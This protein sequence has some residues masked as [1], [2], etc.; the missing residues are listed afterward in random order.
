MKTA[1]AWPVSDRKRYG[2]RT[3]IGLLGSILFLIFISTAVYA[4]QT[5]GPPAH[6][7]TY[8]CSKVQWLQ[9]DHKYLGFSHKSKHQYFFRGKWLQPACEAADCFNPNWDPDCDDQ[10]CFT[11]DWD[12]EVSGKYDEQTD[13]FSENV[14]MTGNIPTKGGGFVKI[15][16]EF[17]VSGK[18]SLDPWIFPTLA[19]SDFTSQCTLDRWT[20]SYGTADQP[21]H[22][23]EIPPIFFSRC[24]FTAEERGALGKEKPV[25]LTCTDSQIKA[26]PTVVFPTPNQNFNDYKDAYAEVKMPCLPPMPDSTANGFNYILEEKIV[27][28]G[29]AQYWLPFCNPCRIDMVPS[30]YN[31]VSRGL[32][33]L[34]LERAGD[35]RI[36]FN[37]QVQTQANLLAGD[38]TDWIYFSARP[39]ISSKLDRTKTQKVSAG[40]LQ[41]ATAPA[42]IVNNIRV[43]PQRPKAGQV[44]EIWIDFFNKGKGPTKATQKYYA[45]C[46][47][48]NGGPPVWNPGPHPLEHIIPPNQS[49]QVVFKGS[50]KDSGNYV[51][52]IKPDPMAS[53]VTFAKMITFTVDPP[54]SPQLKVKPKSG[55][56]QK[57]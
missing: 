13:R 57:P 52:A 51:L 3:L 31:Y 25:P 48:Q 17:L 41:S 1:V 46:T 18:M 2:M 16:R 30:Q 24:A 38:Y 27:E 29:G 6:E 7:D 34:N 32:K 14:K 4:K 9:K 47:P 12:I 10:S 40:A 36:K 15:Y 45:T 50:I 55:V 56:M 21:H 8:D 53:D 54:L 37:Q 33:K 5:F 35:Y 26:K 20:N 42:V 39:L 44:F 43:N 49:V 23:Y 22:Y 19:V 28:Q 11:Q